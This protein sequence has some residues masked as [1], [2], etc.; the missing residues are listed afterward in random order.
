ML[1]HSTFSMRKYNSGILAP[2]NVPSAGIV[3]WFSYFH[4]DS[5][6]CKS[7][8]QTAEAENF[9]RC[10]CVGKSIPF[11]SFNFGSIFPS[12]ILGLQNGTLEKQHS[13][14]GRVNFGCQP[15]KISVIS[16]NLSWDMSNLLNIQ[17]KLLNIYQLSIPCMYSSQ[18]NSSDLPH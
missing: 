7:N 13:T 18:N 4:K 9:R 6:V 1:N 14:C 10:E 5:C 3:Y 11:H 8:V 2:F 17:E 15:K 16:G 12:P